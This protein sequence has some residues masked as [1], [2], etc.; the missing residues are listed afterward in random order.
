[1]DLD[2]QVIERLYILIALAIGF[3]DIHTTYS[4]H[5]HTFVIASTGS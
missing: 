4:R 2:T 1:L 5:H 3:A